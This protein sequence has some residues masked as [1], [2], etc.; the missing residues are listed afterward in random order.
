MSHIK[1]Y[2]KE[3]KQTFLDE[4]IEL[5]KIP[6]VSADSAF[7]KDVLL[8]AD[9]I[10][11]SLHKAGC[12]KVEL[13]ETPGYPIV[14]GEKIID[15]NLPTV[16]VYGHYDVQPADPIE[17]WTSPPFEPVIKETEIHPEGAIFARGACDDK[18]QMYMHVK[19][20]EYMTSTGNLPCNIKFMIEGEEE[21]GSESLS[22]FVLR[23][24]EKLANDVILISDTGMITNTIPSITTGLRGLSYV[25]VEVTGPNRDLHSCS[26]S[27]NRNFK[28]IVASGTFNY[29]VIQNASE[30][31]EFIMKCLIKLWRKTSQLL[32][33][34]L[35]I[36]EQNGPYISPAG[37]YY[38][39]PDVI[40]NS[41]E[42][43]LG[44]CTVINN[45][46]LP[47]DRTFVIQT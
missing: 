20:L 35:Q 14:Y 25:E 24:K 32:V 1:S 2:I 43:L 27:P 36:D 11:N 8:T 7:K 12:D 46:R 15:K 13:C 45:N 34:N 47:K 40:Q 4:L 9:F 18:G 21:V 5:L 28:C 33:F 37:I 30:W 44:N 22:W 29:S 26:P 23:N 42:K 39:Q 41:I 19:A 38:A 17:L 3:H 6:S 16:L 10:L 31:E